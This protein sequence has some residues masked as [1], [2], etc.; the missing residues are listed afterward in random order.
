ML[1]IGLP[2]A[3]IMATMG[4]KSNLVKEVCLGETRLFRRVDFQAIMWTL[5]RCDVRNFPTP[6]QDLGERRHLPSL[7]YNLFTLPHILFANPNLL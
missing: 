3:F 4:W 5:N 2:D 7:T 1:E 6:Q